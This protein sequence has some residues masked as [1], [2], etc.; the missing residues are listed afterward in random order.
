MGAPPCHRANRGQV[1]SPR[2][3]DGTSPVEIGPP[4]TDPVR[5]NLR[6][7]RHQEGIA[8]TV[9]GE[10]ESAIDDQIEP[11][12]RAAEAA[13]AALDGSD[14]DFEWAAIIDTQDDVLHSLFRIGALTAPQTIGPVHLTPG[15]V[16]LR[17]H[18]V[19]PDHLYTESGGFRYTFPVVAEGQVRTYDWEQA[20]TASRYCLRRTCAV[21]T[22]CT[23]AL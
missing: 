14:H 20:G 19:R 3:T 5:S 22:A 18:V 4:M 23:G 1:A 12:R 7:E 21:L 8:C 2:G 9:I 13:V 11:W 16:C 15:G 6:V 17:T 10:D